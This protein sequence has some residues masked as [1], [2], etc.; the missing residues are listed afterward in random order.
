MIIMVIIQKGG[1]FGAGTMDNGDTP[2][3]VLR[4][5]IF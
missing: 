4:Q 2:L 5:A 3:R 1:L